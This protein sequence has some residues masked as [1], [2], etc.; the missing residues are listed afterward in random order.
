MKAMMSACLFSS[1]ALTAAAHAQE[2][3]EIVVTAQKRSEN[4]Q[5]VP[6]SITSLGGE[7]TRSAGIR[8][9]EDFG[10]L[11]PG[12]NVTRS[13]NTSVIYL[14]GVGSTGGS[15]GQENA[16]ATFVDGVYYASMAATVFSLNSIDRIEI[17]KGPQGTLYGRNAT[18]GA[19]NV[20]TR[21]PS[22]ELSMEMDVG[23]GNLDTI[24]ANFYGTTGIAEGLSANLAVHYSNQMKGFGRN[25]V[26][27]RTVNNRKDF[28]IRGKLKFEPSDSTSIILA[29]DYGNSSGSLGAAAR[30]MSSS[31]LLNGQQGYRYGF[32]DVQSNVQPDSFVK[33]G[34][35]SLKIDH[36]M[37]WARTVSITAYRKLRSFQFIDSDLT[38]AQIL[39]FPSYTQEGSFTQ[40]LQL[41]S[42]ADSK[43]QWIVGAFYLKGYSKWDPFTL[44]GDIIAPLTRI[45]VNSR[46]GT[47]SI[48]AFAQTTIPLGEAT[49]LTI[50]GRYTY[51]KRDIRSEGFGEI[52]PTVSFPIDTYFGDQSKSFKKPT[53]KIGIDHEFTDD[54]MAYLT[55]S[56]GFKSGAYNTV[57]PQDRPVNPEILD[58]YEFGVKS[59]LFD[60][61]LR[62]NFAAFYYDYSGVQLTRVVTGGSQIILNAAKAEIYGVDFDFEAAV[63]ERFTLQGGM[64]W[65]HH[66]Y[67]SFPGAPITTPNPQSPYGNITVEGSAAGN[68]M[69]RTP[70][71]QA[72]ISANY[73]IPIGSNEITANISYSYNDGFYW[74]PDNRI[75]QPSYHLVNT[76]L[77]W[78]SSEESYSVKLWTRNL[79]NEKYLYQVFEQ[80]PGDFALPA[81]GRTYGVTLGAKF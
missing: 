32:W 17:L 50:G 54:I 61:R 18:G 45:T 42:P 21:D 69:I 2:V 75:R 48:A 8:T 19:I 28:D 72:S 47:E 20:I 1:F 74:E 25:I 71:F 36:D 33:Q 77:S 6:I 30:P 9:T 39:D 78:V 66:R 14:R 41:L 31:S 51:D 13:T 73:T 38:E 58:A 68:R 49:D 59:V 37:G 63:S 55:Y 24:D 62:A 7:L 16:V 46:Q 57:R 80:G 67:K 76:Q 79:L 52:G 60:R 3:G 34:G 44:I 22:D 64:E 27:G 15:A 70:D 26:N 23:Y 10:V 35:G 65:L 29:G 43:L 11:S 12:V 53:W 81:P 4:L 40:E 5:T 56:R